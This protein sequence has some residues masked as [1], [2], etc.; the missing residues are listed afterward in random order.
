MPRT[1]TNLPEYD[2]IATIRF[3]WNF[4]C[5]EWSS[6]PGQICLSCMRWVEAASRWFWWCAETVPV[7]TFCAP[8]S[9]LA[10]SL[11]R[12]LL[13]F[14]RCSIALNRRIWHGLI[15]LWVKSGKRT[16]A[17]IIN[18]VKWVTS[19]N[20]LWLVYHSGPS[21][22]AGSAVARQTFVFSL[23]E[24]LW[25]ISAACFGTVPLENTHAP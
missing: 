22:I 23:V 25:S 8:V 18:L 19:W 5:L 14:Q 13:S 15:W 1:P 21:M 11:C 9:L 6:V 12:C 10:L 16:L 24:R 4:I 7:Y 2:S 17:G 3:R 20:L